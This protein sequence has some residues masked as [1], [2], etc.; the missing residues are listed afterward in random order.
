MR[1]HPLFCRCAVVAGV[2]I[3]ISLT[4]GPP[5]SL[6]AAALK[7]SLAVRSTA[8]KR[9]R[10][11]AP[12]G[13]GTAHQTAPGE[14][15]TTLRSPLRN[16]DDDRLLQVLAAVASTAATQR[17]HE[18]LARTARI[19]DGQDTESHAQQ[20]LEPLRAHENRRRGLALQRHQ[21]GAQRELTLHQALQ[22]ARTQAQPQPQPDQQTFLWNLY[23]GRVKDQTV[24]EWKRPFGLQQS[25]STA[26]AAPATAG[27]QATTVG[28][29]PGWNR[30]EPAATQTRTQSLSQTRA[31]VAAA[32][33]RALAADGA[34][35]TRS[36]QEN[37]INHRQLQNAIQAQFSR[38]MAQ[39][40]T[41][42]RDGGWKA[43]LV[44]ER[45]RLA[46]QSASQPQQL[47]HV[48]AAAHR[49][50]RASRAE[51]ERE[52]RQAQLQLRA[53]IDALA[54]A[55]R[56]RSGSLT[57]PGSRGFALDFRQWQQAIHEITGREADPQRNQAQ[58][59]SKRRRIGNG[60]PADRSASGNPAGP[61]ST[62][63]TTANM[64]DRSLRTTL[65]EFTG[66]YYSPRA[67]DAPAP[68]SYADAGFVLPTRRQQQPNIEPITP[69][70]PM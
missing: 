3:S 50:V 32:L 30:P 8:G 18:V 5:P 42:S 62:E 24:A 33:Q 61:G 11:E 23:A 47:S 27:P 16:Q 10:E 39:N 69:E 59:G 46:A 56:S 53:Q 20:D 4:D 57:R 14:T 65:G 1:M 55:R 51:L 52:V 66:T 25:A 26:A 63:S 17:D 15:P 43:E 67:R 35:L 36:L 6:E 12:E 38:Q 28:G 41:L 58:I 44:T 40:G 13:P 21:G 37:E 2:C 9:A 19:Q 31:E 7:V 29:V 45:E 60:N 54:R 49:A 68:P 22:R 64:E 34:W 48:D 70:M